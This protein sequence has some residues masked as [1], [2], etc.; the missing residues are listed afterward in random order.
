[1]QNKLS[2]QQP[3]RSGSDYPFVVGGEELSKVVLDAAVEHAA[4]ARLP[5]RVTL[6][7]GLNGDNEQPENI[8]I[9]IS[10]RENDVIFDTQADEYVGSHTWG[11]YYSTHTWVSSDSRLLRVTT[12]QAYRDGF[13]SALPGISAVLD[14]RSYVPVLPGIKTLN[15][16]DQQEKLAEI[17]SNADVTRLR[18]GYNVN[19]TMP[20]AT[21]RTRVGGNYTQTVLLDAVPQN[22][23]G[24]FPGC[25]DAADPIVRSFNRQGPAPSGNFLL[26]GTECFRVE[27]V[28]TF[29]DE[30]VATIQ[31]GEIR[32][33]DDCSAC[34]DCEDYLRPYY[35]VQR[36]K[37]FIDP[38][39]TLFQDIR[40]RYTTVV[41]RVQESINCL[42]RRQLRLEIFTHTECEVTVVAGVFNGSL[43][44]AYNTGLT[45]YVLWERN[46]QWVPAE[47]TTVPAYALNHTNESG[48]DLTPLT[49]HDDGRITFQVDCT[50]TNELRQ[51][52]FRVG[53]T[54]SQPVKVCLGFSEASS[55]PFICR[56]AIT[57]CSQ[58]QAE[59]P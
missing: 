37:R 34:C 52:S 32:L 56:S 17:N 46:G 41:S 9:V 2:V 3:P 42:S 33:F 25:G 35:A 20:A 24:Q 10:D 23:L 40:Q 30:G 28:V 26:N 14:P 13:P 18:R 39:I 1:M 38:L 55:E 48:G 31:H 6:A 45:V 50:A 44:P 47:L 43:Q 19:Y 51:I 15:I 27:P 16:Y 21:L 54:G 53:L 29:D 12:G 7:E 58:Q 8:R 36:A 22:G 4:D 59:Q 11:I 5:L 57:R 49:Q